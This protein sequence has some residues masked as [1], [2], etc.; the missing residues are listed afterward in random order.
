MLTFVVVKILELNSAQ[1][2]SALAH[3]FLCVFS[4]TSGCPA[5]C[6]FVAELDASCKILQRYRITESLSPFH[7]HLCLSNRHTACMR[8]ALNGQGSKATCDS[9]ERV[10]GPHTELISQANL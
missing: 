2:H 7:L 1:N 9:P 5:L 6:A 8:Q 4:D 3:V 10:K